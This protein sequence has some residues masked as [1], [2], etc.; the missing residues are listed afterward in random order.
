MHCIPS[1]AGK[2]EVAG[3]LALYGIEHYCPLQ[4]IQRK[5]SDRKKIIMEPLFKSYVFVRVPGERTIRS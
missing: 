5:W 2:R 4:R 1:L 3:L